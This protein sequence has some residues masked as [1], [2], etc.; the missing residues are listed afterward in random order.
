MR[1]PGVAAILAVVALAGGVALA[2]PLPKAE[3]NFARPDERMVRLGQLLFHDKIISGN[4]NIACATCHHPRFGTSDGLS[5]GF[6]EGGVG[7]GPDRRPDPE[8]MPERRIPRNA[9]AL[10][11]LGASGFTSMFHDGRLEADRSSPGGMR[12]PLGEDMVAGFDS[13][14]AAQAMFPVIAAD[15][16]AGH[17]GE[18][19]I[20]RA[21]SEG[22]LASD[23]GAWDR[24]AA[25]VAAIPAYAEAFRPIIGDRR[26]RFTDVANAIAAF[27]ATEFRADDS[28][29]DRYLKTGAPM[30]PA[31]MR[32]MNLFYGKAGCDTCHSGLFQTDNRFHAIAMPQIGPGKAASF[33]NHHRDEG[34]MRVTGDSADAYAFRTPS[35]R[36]V[37]L[38]AP[39]GHDGAY[40]TLEA[41]VRHHLNPV[42]SL[43]AY[44]PSQAVL[45]PFENDSDF[46][47]LANEA[48]V[49]AIAEAN[50]LQP[51]ALTDSEVADLIA[52]LD[53]LTDRSFETR[54]LGV[55]KTVPSGLPVDQ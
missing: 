19:D 52:F 18:N 13:V 23:G 47:E 6:G 27:V 39:Y 31:A 38:T 40:A 49:N 1:G 21:V 12:T 55:P 44:D 29:F 17:Y 42:A 22:L 48:D 35:L 37:A 11:N 9:P 8:N 51:V 10:F 5:L 30:A 41:V 28:P 15:E 16:M 26:L 50:E 14:L 43:R 2:G 3:A 45:P 54:G 32:G 24:I 33:E 25:R 46:V 4:R 36:N 20:S 34:R 53:A 7:L